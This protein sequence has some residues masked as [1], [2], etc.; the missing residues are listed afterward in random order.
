[1]IAVLVVMTPRRGERRIGCR[2][3]PRT[4]EV[5]GIGQQLGERQLGEIVG[6]EPANRDALAR[7]TKHAV[8]VET[9]CDDGPLVDGNDAEVPSNEPR[10]GHDRIIRRALGAARPSV[11]TRCCAP[12][13]AR[14]IDLDSGGIAARPTLPGD[15]IG[16]ISVSMQRIW[17]KLAPS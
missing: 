11:R 12:D 9:C 16:E 13:R 6:N 14:A 7:M 3:V 1:M 5:A 10:E 4:V 15:T 17:G 2:T 8:D